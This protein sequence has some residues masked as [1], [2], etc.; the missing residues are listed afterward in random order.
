M[1]FVP[2]WI[3]GALLGLACGGS[4]EPPPAVGTLE[5]D[6]VELTAESNDP[7]VEIAVREGDRVRRGQLLLRLDEAQL[8][9]LRL[10][11]EARRDQALARLAEL[12][13]GPRQEAIAEARARLAGA[14][15]GLANARRELAR[16]EA[17]RSADYES[18]QRRDQLREHRDEAVARRDQARAGYDAMIE[19]TTSEELAQARSA[20]AA[21]ESALA[22]ASVR[23]DRL[24]VRAP[25]DAHVDALPFEFGERPPPGA[26]VVVLLAEGAPYARVYV[27]ETLRIQLRPGVRA[28][29]HVDGLDEP[30]AGRVRVVSHDAAFT[31]YFALTQHDRGRLAYVA[32]V[33]LEDAAA[34]ELPTGIPVEVRFE[35]TTVVRRPEA[36][37][38]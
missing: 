15:S 33:D 34:A 30:L 18:E 6:R 3:L 23:V 9:A 37:G 29:V 5:R 38:P 32:E 20:L 36:P 14:E 11:R 1:R 8:G 22:A 13:R 35:P 27:P 17:L 4:E 26:T 21:A 10:E 7:I 19:G 28:R 12:E 16:V 31:P 25:V 24:S 2:R